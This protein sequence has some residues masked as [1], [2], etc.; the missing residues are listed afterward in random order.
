M[1]ISNSQT[2]GRGPSHF[3]RSTECRAMERGLLRM[4]MG[5]VTAFGMDLTLDP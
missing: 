1:G 5:I 4:G 2:P 3:L